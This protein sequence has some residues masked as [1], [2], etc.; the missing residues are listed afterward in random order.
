MVVK[1]VSGVFFLIVL[2]QMLHEKVHGVVGV[3]QQYVS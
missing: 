1:F 3:C 2:G